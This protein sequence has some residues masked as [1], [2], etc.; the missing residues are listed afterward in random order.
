MPSVLC[1]TTAFIRCVFSFSFC[2]WEAFCHPVTRSSLLQSQQH[3]LRSA[4]LLEAGALSLR[5]WT[6]PLRRSSSRP[7]A[8]L[9]QSGARRG[10]EGALEAARASG[11][12][13]RGPERSPRGPG[14]RRGGRIPPGRLRTQSVRAHQEGSAASLM[15][16]LWQSRRSACTSVLSVGATL[17]PRRGMT[18]PPP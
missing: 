6:W 3:C 10:R 13:S 18:P 11:A 9:Q 8:Q 14:W 4:L 5:A 15:P 7:A 2:R 12:G 17:A 1:P 16:W